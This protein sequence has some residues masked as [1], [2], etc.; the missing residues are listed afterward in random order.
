MPLTRKLYA[1]RMESVAE[2]SRRRF[3]G[4]GCRDAAHRGQSVNRSTGIPGISRFVEVDR[5]KRPPARYVRIGVYLG[6]GK[7]VRFNLGREGSF[8]PEHE[9]AMLE[10]AVAYR[11]KVVPPSD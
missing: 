3:C 4:A 8:S 1:S 10:L 6:K 7:I 5:R 9:A 11:N 2:F